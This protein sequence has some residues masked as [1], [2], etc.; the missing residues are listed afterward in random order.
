MDLTVETF[1]EGTWHEAAIVNLEAPE[2]GY[3]TPSRTSYEMGY[4]AKFGAIPFAEDRPLKGVHAYSINAPVDLVD[5]AASTWPAFLLDLI[6][7]GHHAERIARFLNLP[8]EAPSTQVHLLMRAAS[9]PVGNIRIKEA[10]DQEVERL[11]DISVAGITMEEILDR[12]DAFLEVA[13]RFSLL[14]SGSSGLQGD[15]PKVSLTRSRD[16]LWYPN[17]M[18]PDADALEF[19]IVKLLRSDEPVD[20]RILESESGYSVVA[21]EFGVNVERTSTYGNGV[22]VIPRFD[23]RVTSGGLIRYGQESL[24]SAIGVAEFAFQSRHETYLKTIQQVSSCP[25][26]DT[27]EYLLRDVLNL[28]MG[29]PDNHG[30]NA[31][32]RKFPDGSIRLAPLFDFAPMKIATA[33]IVRSTRWGCMLDGGGQDTNPDWRLVCETVSSPKVPAHKLMSALAAKEDLLRALPEIARKCGVPVSVVTNAIIRNED[34][35]NGVA[36]LRNVTD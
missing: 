29:N 12:S 28:A 26:E 17:S 1:I 18:V 22:L 9:S 15:W 11:Q 7:Q 2:K 14:A 31:A 24:V 20:Q 34:M 33:G 30:R 8:V 13:D 19:I 21:K 3:T 5:R 23:R 35:A 27:T 36:K 16:G 4:F 10:Y 25:L 6:P 32:L